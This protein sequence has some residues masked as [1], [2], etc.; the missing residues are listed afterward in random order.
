MTYVEMRHNGI[1]SDINTD[2]EII[3]RIGEIVD[4][5]DGENRHIFKVDRVV[6]IYEN[7]KIN[8]IYISGQ[9]M[10]DWSIMKK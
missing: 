8:M 2:M 3:P 5:R 9:E 4:F 10:K 6:H 1:S 7:H